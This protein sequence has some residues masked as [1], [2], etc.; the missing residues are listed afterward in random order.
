MK[1]KFEV[2]Y[3]V[4]NNKLLFNKYK[5]ILSLEK[6]GVQMG[7]SYISD[8]ACTNF[9][10]FIGLDLKDQLYKDLAKAKFFT[11]LSDGSTDSLL[12]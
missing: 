6:H 1:R 11:V 8:T 2:A 7:D 9:I 10:D 3:F 4:A 5:E 12:I